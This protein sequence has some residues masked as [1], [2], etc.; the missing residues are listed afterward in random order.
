MRVK[1]WG[2]WQPNRCSG[3]PPK[4]PSPDQ[5]AAGY[6]MFNAKRAEDGCVKVILKTPAA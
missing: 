6:E 3:L 2:A 1:D 4:T 5:A